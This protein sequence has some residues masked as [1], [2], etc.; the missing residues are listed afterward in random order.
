MIYFYTITLVYICISVYV[1]LYPQINTNNFIGRGIT[2]A[3]YLLIVKH[4]IRRNNAKLIK[5]IVEF[6]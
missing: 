6:R 1:P 5:R 4:L 2:E 3:N